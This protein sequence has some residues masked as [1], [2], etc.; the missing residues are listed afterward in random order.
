MSVPNPSILVLPRP[1]L[2]RQ[3]FSS[4]SDAALRQLGGVSFNDQERDF[5][6]EQLAAVIDNYDVVITSWRSPRFTDEVLAAARRLKLVA[7]SAGSIRF[8][9]S[10]ESLERGFDVTC[11]A[12]AMA[13]AVAEYS[14]MLTMLLLRPIHKY[15]RALKSGEDWMAVKSAGTALEIANQRVGVIGAGHTGRAFIRLLNCVGAKLWVYDPYLS[16]QDAR[17]LNAKRIDSLDH[18][19]ESCRIVSLQAPVTDETRHMIGQREL[20]LLPDGALLVNTA[21]SA[22]VDTDAL[23]AELQSGR[24]SAAIDVFD[25]EPLPAGSPFR[26]LDNC[27]ISPHLAGHTVETHYRQGAMCV[28]EVRRFMQG[29]PLKYA[30]TRKMMATMA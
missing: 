25:E 26:G 1:S 18:L 21:R 28:D 3:L 8:M 23:L 6:S 16:E 17:E 30:I 24:I 15:D 10:Q 4:D 9:F 20:A 29:K 19:L 5:T 14:L 13:P 12:A 2:Y 11:V 22:L 27:I 7:H